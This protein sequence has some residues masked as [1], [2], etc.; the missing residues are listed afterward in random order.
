MSVN[1]DVLIFLTGP[2]RIPCAKKGHGALPG[3]YQWSLQ[4]W[5]EIAVL[6]TYNILYPHVWNV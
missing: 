3:S 4:L 6:S 2:L 1:K 5:P